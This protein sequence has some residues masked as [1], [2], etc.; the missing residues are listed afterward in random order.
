[1]QLFIAALINLFSLFKLWVKF[2]M[3]LISRDTSSSTDLMNFRSYQYGLIY[4]F[5]KISFEYINRFGFDCNNYS[6]EI[7]QD[8]T[9]HSKNH[10][11]FDKLRIKLNNSKNNFL[12]LDIPKLIDGMFFKLK[13][14]YYVPLIYILDEPVT[15]K[16]SSI[17]LNSLF[18][19]IT[20]YTNDNRVILNGHNIPISRFLRLYSPDE[21]TTK[22][23]CELFKTQ[24]MQESLDESVYNISKLILCKNDLD[25]LIAFIE[26]TFFDGWTKGLYQAHYQKENINMISIFEIIIDRIIKKQH[27]E[28][29]DLTHKRLVFIE[30]ILDPLFK[31]INRFISS[32]KRNTDQAHIPI[33]ANAIINHF[34]SSGNMGIGVQKKYRGLSGNNLYSIVNGF[35]GLIGLKAS[36]E[37]PKSQS[38]LPKSI[39]SIHENYKGKICPVTISNK[40]PGVISTL[41]PDQKIDL[42]YGLFQ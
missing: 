3:N 16:K 38:E 22:E 6:V 33:K 20:L 37:N 4:D 8:K 18:R 36:F 23:V 2:Q 32:I 11:A 5:I 29:N 42:R 14:V 25:S 24:Y 10:Y 1:M 21:G 19:P 35:S 30:L 12:E 27:I 17:K 41:V 28:F 13:G 26:N 39:S 15:F 9:Y 40:N 7:L 34:Y 31:S